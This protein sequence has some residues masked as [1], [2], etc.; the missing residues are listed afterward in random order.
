MKPDVEL[1]VEKF[2][3]AL[4]SEDASVFL[5]AGASKSAGYVDWQQLLEPVAKELNLNGSQETDL[6]ALA[7]FHVNES[8]QNRSVINQTILDQL[9]KNLEPTE[10]H[11]VLAKLPIPVYWT[12]NYDCLVEQ[13]LRDEGKVV[14]V[15]HT[16]SQLANSR[17]K[18]DAVVY[19][20][21]GDIEHP[22]EAIITK[23]DYEH[24]YKKQGAFVNALSGDLISRTF[25][26]IGFSF[27]DPNLDY[28]LS[29][30]RVNFRDHQRRHFAFFRARKRLVSESESDF[31]NAVTR[32][33]LMIEDL[34]RFNI[35]AIL[36]DEYS[37]ITE[38]LREV[39]RRFRMK[40][41]FVS[42]SASSFDPWGTER[43]T[44]FMRKLGNLLVDNSLRVATGLG[45][46]VGNALFTGALEQ[47]YRS[48]ERRI[49]DH[50]LL[51][52]FPQFV[53]NP[54]EQEQLW[55]KYRNDF[56]PSSG[57]ALFLF[58]NKFVDG[59]LVG[60][61]GMV[62]EF[63]IAAKN[64]LVLL[65]IGATGSTASDL[66]HRLFSDPASFP[67]VSEAI[68]D[69]L[70]GVADPVQNLDTLIQPILDL[71]KAASRT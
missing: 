35:R 58:G 66:A 70:R 45:L 22:N 12:T 54:G 3:A 52:P 20:M 48:P 36:V 56:I 24:Y 32:Q 63:E 11:R 10:N 68:L 23:D 29:R 25:L 39:L 34:K 71:V 38:A 26:F 15:K 31:Q 65:P 37:E 50:L 55:D 2:V 44:D 7:Q 17:S 46:G 43:V 47:V 16:V 61:N 33:R 28:I 53:D 4:Q 21:H 60:A 57:M 13:S 64:G 69:G 9:G 27:S 30:I 41:V 49:D 67:S 18:R 42:S 1:F 6:I 62:S 51:R 59:N 19:K 5:G 14:D 40:T 8:G